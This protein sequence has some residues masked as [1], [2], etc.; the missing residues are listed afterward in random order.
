ME[1]KHL[2]K[3]LIARPQRPAPFSSM[4]ANRGK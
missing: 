1:N 4:F 3:P 2:F